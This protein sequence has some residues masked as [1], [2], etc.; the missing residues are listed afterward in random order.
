MDKNEIATALKFAK[1]NSK[2][3]NFKQSID[4][5]INLKDVDLKKPDNQIDIF[6]PLHF[7]TGHIIKVCALVGPELLSQAKDVCDLAISIDEFD[8]YKDKKVAKKLAEEYDYF[9]AQATIMPKVATT[10]GKVF[11]PKAKMPNPKAGCV[12]P[13]NA[14]LKPLYERLQKMV[15]VTI[16]KDPLFQCLVGKEDSKDEEVIDNVLTIYNAV[17]HQL[18]NERHNIKSVYLKLTMGPSIKIG[19]KPQLKDSEKKDEKT[20]EKPKEEQEKTTKEDKI[21]GSK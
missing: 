12:V 5:I 2:K 15:K 8:K 6:V 13:P 11:G 20:S 18:P 3:R 9:I 17:I 19:Q 4:L 14:N 21:A 7:G 16:K 1:E 10:F